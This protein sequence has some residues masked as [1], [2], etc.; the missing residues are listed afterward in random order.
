METVK[1]IRGCWGPPPEATGVQAQPGESS[2]TQG[3]ALC[4]GHP[5]APRS[6]ASTASLGCGHV[7]ES[8]ASCTN[9]VTFAECLLL[10]GTRYYTNGQALREQTVL[11]H[12]TWTVPSVSP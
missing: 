6:P 8:C 9:L 12:A 2:R 10:S 11:P 7:T 1:E 3:R 5:R 4:S